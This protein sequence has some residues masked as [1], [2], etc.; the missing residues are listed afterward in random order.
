MS[1]AKRRH[2]TDRVARVQASKARSYFEANILIEYGA[3][4]PRSKPERGAEYRASYHDRAQGRTFSASGST[5]WEAIGWAIASS[6]AI[7]HNHVIVAINSD[8]T[9]TDYLARLARAIGVAS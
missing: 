9:P 5:P 7:R 6:V 4:G 3:Y 8:D 1:E 2:R